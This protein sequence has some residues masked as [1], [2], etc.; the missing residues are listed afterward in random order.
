MMARFRRPQ[1]TALGTASTAITVF[2]VIL[3]LFII[4]RQA[5]AIDR[6]RANYDSLHASYEQ[7]Y[8]EA[9]DAGAHPD[10]PAPEDIDPAP[11]AEPR[12][13]IPGPS[14]SPGKQ[15]RQGEQ[16]EQGDRGPGPTDQQVRDGVE[17]YC[18]VDGRCS[19]PPAFADVVA[20]VVQVCADGACDGEDGADGADGADGQNATAEM[21]SAAVQ[22][23]CS[24]GACTGPKGDA[25]P[26]PTAEEL[27]PLIEQAIK[28]YCSARPGGTCVGPRGE[29]GQDFSGFTV[30]CDP[31]TQYMV[32]LRVYPGETPT[33][34]CESRSLVDLP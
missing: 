12:L 29:P 9:L 8:S 17:G 5:G 6:L 19:E 26:K 7:L 24:A 27:R 32:G 20:A 28:D 10:A 21:V 1:V 22:S 2:A 33:P 4:V 31:E 3:V 25:G 15:G 34:Y 11:V 16:G 23:Y 30:T 18:A 13:P 14:G